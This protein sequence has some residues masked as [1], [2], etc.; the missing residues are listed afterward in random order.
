MQ[1][2]LQKRDAQTVDLS[3][4]PGGDNGGTGRLAPIED[5]I[6]ETVQRAIRVVAKE[7]HALREERHVNLR[8]Y[9][10]EKSRVLLDLSRLTDA[11]DIKTLSTSVTNELT[12]LKRLLAENREILGR[13]LDAVRE[14]TELLSKAML[15]AESDGTY[16]AQMQER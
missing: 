7:T 11:V 1:T 6:L 4:A 9:S 16:A 3:L 13:H 5:T 14:I 10:D 2:S 15:A 12:V 8:S